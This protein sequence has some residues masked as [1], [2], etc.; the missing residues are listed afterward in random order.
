MGLLIL[1]APAIIG[2]LLGVLVKRWSIAVVCALVA[3][4]ASLSGWIF[5]WAGD[6]DTPAL[7]GAIIFAMLAGMP[8]VGGACLGVWVGR[9]EAERGN[10]ADTLVEVRLDIPPEQR[11]RP[12]RP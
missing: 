5:G 12:Q 6:S 4:A 3:I 2:F 9:S 7:G 10:R 11:P 8:F 1:V